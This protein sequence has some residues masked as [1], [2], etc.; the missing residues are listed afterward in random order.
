MK[1]AGA[2]PVSWNRRLDCCGGAFSLSRTGSV[3]RLSR[4]ILEDARAAGADAVAV[5]CPMCHSNLD[6]RQAA[7]ARRGEEPLPVFFLSELVGLALGLAPKTLGVQRHFVPPSLSSPGW[8]R[9]RSPP[10]QKG[11]CA[12]GPHRRLRLPLRR[13]HRPHR[14]LRQ[15]G[16]GPREASGRRPLL[17]LQV[18]VLGPRPG[19][20][21]AGHR[22]EEPHGRRGGGVLAPHAREDFPPRGIGRRA[23]PLPLRDGQRPRALLVDPR[24]PRAR[25]PR[26]PS[27]SAGPSSR[28]SSATSPSRP[29]TSP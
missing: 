6:F 26:R 21:Q 4:A 14:G 28:R 18:H 2:T 12:D 7:M 9:R 11:G 19:P 1:A 25:P 23:E 29:S 20:R 10:R 13:E 27:T 15:G 17:R 24:G 22:R 5:A 8:P 16:R 3:L